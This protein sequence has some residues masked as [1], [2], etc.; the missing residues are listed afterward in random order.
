MKFPTSLSVQLS[1]IKY[2]N[3]VVHHVQFKNLCTF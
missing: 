3:I 2:I 1:Y